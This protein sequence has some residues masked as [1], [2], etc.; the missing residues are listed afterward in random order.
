MVHVI[1]GP[2]CSGKSTYVREHARPGDLIVDFDIIAQALGSHDA[3]ETDGIVLKAAVYARKAAVNIALSHPDAE[4]WVI[5][6]MPSPDQM[7]EY[8]S[9]GA[10]IIVLDPGMETCMKRAEQ[11]NRPQR[12]LDGIRKWYSKGIEESKKVSDNQYSQI[13][14]DIISRQSSRLREMLSRVPSAGGGSIGMSSRNW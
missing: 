13:Q 3:Y 14:R 1:T 10:E 4:S 2:P 9:A 12:T 6:A 8:R 5:H 11:D 7:Q